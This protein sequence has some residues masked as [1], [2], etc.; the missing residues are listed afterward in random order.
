[1][2]TMCR[3]VAGVYERTVHI[4]HLLDDE[5]QDEE[6]GGP[7]LVEMTCGGYDSKVGSCKWQP[8]AD[9]K[10]MA[11]CGGS[12]CTVWDFNGDG[13]VGSDPIIAAGHMDGVTCQ[14]RGKQ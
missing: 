1:M 6:P 14:V 13:P 12:N 8:G 7:S 10:L 4:W 5:E 11:S 2:H 9:A 3:F